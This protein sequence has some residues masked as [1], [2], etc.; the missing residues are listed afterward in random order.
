L[1]KTTGIILVLVVVLLGI[2]FIVIRGKKNGIA[3]PQTQ[4]TGT[5]TTQ[6][7]L[8]ANATPTSAP[9]PLQIALT[10]DSPANNST[11]TTSSVTVSGRTT[12]N[13]DVFV[14]DT[15]LKANAAGDFSTSV[16][17]DEGDNTLVVGANDSNGNYSEKEITVTYNTGQ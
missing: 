1:N 16:Q 3:S 11:V 17:L 14:N 12:P 5:E 2:G 15:E 8:Q 6:A 4:N 10:V 13:A 7:A 9:E